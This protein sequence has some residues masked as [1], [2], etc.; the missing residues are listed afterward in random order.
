[1]RVWGRPSRLSRSLVAPS[2]TLQLRHTAQSQPRGRLGPRHHAEYRP[3]GAFFRRGGKL[4]G[5]QPAIHRLL[6]CRPHWSPIYMHRK[7]G[8]GS[9]RR[10]DMGHLPPG[11]SATDIRHPGFPV[12]RAVWA[13]TRMAPGGTPPKK[14]QVP[15][16]RTPSVARLPAAPA[17]PRA[18]HGAVC[19]V[20]CSG[21]AC[22]MLARGWARVQCVLSAA[23]FI[24]DFASVFP[25]MGAGR[26]TPSVARFPAAPARPRAPHGAVCFV[27]CSGS[28]CGMLARGW[29][30][31]LAVQHR[32]AVGT[33]CVWHTPVHFP[34]ICET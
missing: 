14:T 33:V 9:C 28:A 1:M 27:T 21:S 12:T 2:L 7:S 16:R 11:A 26:R 20:T 3:R 5:P 10:C 32:R 34:H 13:E 17:R 31:G 22:G 30:R 18:P 25:D 8:R 15:G 6:G 24:C 4:P 19:F 23:P 29:A